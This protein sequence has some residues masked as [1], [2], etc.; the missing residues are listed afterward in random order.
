LA[1][2]VLIPATAAQAQFEFQVGQGAESLPFAVIDETAPIRNLFERADG[3]A[4]RGDWKLV[5]DSLQRIIARPQAALVP[6]VDRPDGNTQGIG[7]A[8]RAGEGGRSAPGR[9]GGRAAKPARPDAGDGR[10]ESARRAAVRYLAALPVEALGAYR[11]LYDGHA[12][13]LLD[14]GLTTG[15]REPVEKLAEEYFHTS[16][17]D[18]ACDLLAS[19]ALDRGRPVEALFWL[20]RLR[21]FYPG[22]DVP[23]ARLEA[24]RLAA[25]AMIERAD[26]IEQARRTGPQ[27]IAR[28]DRAVDAALASWRPEPTHGDDW[29]MLGGTAA[30]SFVMP[31]ASPTLTVDDVWSAMSP[32]GRTDEWDYYVRSRRTGEVI[33]PS[34]YAV[35]ADGRI[36]VRTLDGC[37]AL[38]LEGLGWVW[39]SRPRSA[40]P[41]ERGGDTGLA[42]VSTRNRLF[43]DPLGSSLAY[44]DGLVTCL[45]ADWRSVP[46]EGFSRRRRFP[47]GIVDPPFH[48]SRLVAFDAAT[49]DVRWTLGD[50]DVIDARQ[51][52]RF[53]GTPVSV[54]GGWWAP[55]FAGRDLC[56][57]RIDPLRGRLLERVLVC[58]LTSWPA[59]DRS[60]LDLAVG[61]GLV[62]V[63][64]GAG[65][66]AAVDVGQRSVEWVAYYRPPSQ[67]RSG[68]RVR[69]EDR[70]Q[71]PLVLAGDVLVTAPVDAPV[72]IALDAG[73]GRELWRRDVDP[74][75]YV[76]AAAGE[77]VFL[78]GKDIVRLETGS[79]RETWAVPLPGTQTGRT[80]LS[81]DS[82][83]CPTT[84]GLVRVSA[85]TGRIVDTLSLPGGGAPLGNLLVAGGALFSI[86]GAS[87]RKFPDFELSYPRAAAAHD[88]DPYDVRA[89]VRLAWL[90]LLQQ[91]PAAARAVLDVIQPAAWQAGGVTASERSRLEVRVLLALAAAE[92]DGR[93][94]I[95]LTRQAIEAARTDDDRLVAALAYGR[96]A[97]QAGEALDALRALWRLAV[98]EAAARLVPTTAGARAPQRTE[99]GR[100]IDT[101]WQRLESQEREA[102]ASWVRQRIAEQEANLGDPRTA[103]A[104]LSALKSASV[105]PGAAGSDRL[106]LDVLARYYERGRQYEIAEH[107][108]QRLIRNDEGSTAGLCARMRLCD[109][110][111]I[112]GFGRPQFRAALWDALRARFGHLPIPP[113][114]DGDRRGAAT[115]DEWVSKSRA[116]AEPS[117]DRDDQPISYVFAE[118]RPG[119]RA[120][121][122]DDMRRALIERIIRVDG[123]AGELDSSQW[124]AYGPGHVLRAREPVSGQLVWQAAL[125]MG[126][127]F[128][129]D[130]S[131]VHLVGQQARRA[132][133]NG[134]IL[135][136]SS[137]YGLHAVGISTGKR[138]WN[139]P[140]DIP[141][142]DAG[143]AARDRALAVNQTALAATPREGAVTLMS[144]ADGQ[145]TWEADLGGLTVAELAIVDDLVV[146]IDPAHEYVVVLD[147][148]TGARRSE[149]EFRQPDPDVDLADL[150]IDGQIIIGPEFDDRQERIVAFDLATGQ[151]RWHVSLSGTLVQLFKPAAGYVGAGLLAGD[152]LVLDAADG[153]VVT[154]GA[155]RGARAVVAGGLRDRVLVVEYTS[156]PRGDMRRLAGL[157]VGSGKVLWRRDD[158]IRLPCG[159]P[160]RFPVAIEEVREHD[161]AVIGVSVAMLDGLTGEVIGGRAPLRGEN[162]RDGLTGDFV[163]IGDRYIAATERGYLF[164]RLQS[165]TEGSGS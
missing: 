80:I 105:L 128:A 165:T 139:R 86:E 157:E 42:R 96:R 85:S 135:V 94:A 90:E 98:S 82:L 7:D 71:T 34:R 57:G 60:V 124:I 65:A 46:Q 24:K 40:A 89:A 50:E 49:G 44:V 45:D 120:F 78:G 10:Y 138:L 69:D 141:L 62:Y 75:R 113:E 53:V 102:F 122:T 41:F 163:L 125:A 79:G 25:N 33:I 123:M 14:E 30:R 140:Y 132:V 126:G 59:G 9:R 52:R 158:V 58:S 121:D 106:A 51:T 68:G 112:R 21:D 99:L 84:R 150:I 66:V 100:W 161:R 35:V 130:P 109:L 118:D 55:F 23:P 87:V 17:G 108:L 110:H 16:Y 143:A 5:I 154:D 18:D 61:G 63:A 97:Q 162:S 127:D 47:I 81:G 39:Q 111:A 54:E 2:V 77:A 70:R 15:R 142:S 3:G 148:A 155:V 83:L 145:T 101:L 91:R 43:E 72:C 38:D 95:A 151:V 37:A 36:Y 67:E 144:L 160:W 73:S 103:R 146:A 27:T 156:R 13:R 137:A 114:F 64:T 136:V 22:S 56:L 12:R 117:P 19:D 4:A 48:P 32:D 20:N 74:E 159:S 107:Y 164:Y 129:T 28:G 8:T 88:A 11:T 26:R 152:V 119:Q 149:I 104:A 93:T 116:A 147:L 115:V 1:L 29:P 31:L 6:V 76:I 133:C 134:S 131:N 92:P 153:S